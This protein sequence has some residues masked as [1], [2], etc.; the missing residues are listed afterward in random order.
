VEWSDVAPA[1]FLPP[2]DPGG[3][4]RRTLIADVEVLS[5]GLICPNPVG[6]DLRSRVGFLFA[7][8]TETNISVPPGETMAEIRFPLVTN[9]PGQP[10]HIHSEAILRVLSA[11]SSNSFRPIV[12][13]ADGNGMADGAPTG[14]FEVET[15]VDGMPMTL[16]GLR[17]GV[18]FGLSPLDGATPHLIVEFS[19][20]LLL[21]PEFIDASI[22]AAGLFPPC[23]TA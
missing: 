22:A 2:S 3:L 14:F 11:I 23:R 13:D 1:G 15:E 20:P 8:S 17:V 12:I 16:D 6:A 21:D 9:G 10:S 4:P 5:Y 7:S 19:L 18:G